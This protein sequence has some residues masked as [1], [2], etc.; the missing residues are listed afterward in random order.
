MSLKSD[1]L[2]VG[3]SVYGKNLLRNRQADFHET[4]CVA[5]GTPEIIVCSNND[6]GVTLT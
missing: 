2:E 3:G 5:F 6:P 1:Q 4:W